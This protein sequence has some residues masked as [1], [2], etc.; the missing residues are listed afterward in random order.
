M[1]LTITPSPVPTGESFSKFTYDFIVEREAYVR[2]IYIR[3]KGVRDEFF[4]NAKPML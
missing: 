1:A 3:T 2:R 4:L